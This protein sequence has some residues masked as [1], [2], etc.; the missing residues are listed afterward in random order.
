GYFFYSRL[1]FYFSLLARDRL[2]YDERLFILRWE[3]MSYLITLLAPGMVTWTLVTLAPAGWLAMGL[4]LA[5]LGLPSRTLLEEAIAAED[6]NKVHLA[7][8]ALTTTLT[9]HDALSALESLAYRLLDWGDFRVYR[10][11]A[12]GDPDLLYR[13]AHGRPDRWTPSPAL[14]GVRAEV[15]AG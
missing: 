14:E 15:I 13:S 1:L 3:V 10:S 9:L 4:A 2:A 5:V 12:H 8:A 7:Q 11:S 6:L